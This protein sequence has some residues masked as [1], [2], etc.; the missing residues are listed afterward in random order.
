MTR[1]TAIE[2][3]AD[4]PG[5]F[6]T[7]GVL[8]YRV[9]IARPGN[10]YVVFPGGYTN[11]PYSWDNFHNDTWETF[12]AA[13]NSNLEIFNASNDRNS[14]VYPVFRRNFQTVYTA[15][16]TSGQLLLRSTIADLSDDKVFGFQHYF[17]DRLKGRATELSSFKNIVIRARTTGA[18]PVR[19]RISLITKDAFCFSAYVDLTSELKEIVVPITS[20]RPDSCLLLPRPYPGFMPLWFKASGNS[21]F[22]V[23][24]AE[25]LEF[26]IGSDLPASSLKQA[27]GYEVEKVWLKK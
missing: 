21:V 22:S 12:V 24:D 2:Y 26:T 4:I 1:K 18:N 6:I 27:Y 7:P 8:R 13:E 3:L 17:G 15:G 11:N 9:I 10:R 25:K 16:E 5:D 23:A 20:L 14:F 19:A